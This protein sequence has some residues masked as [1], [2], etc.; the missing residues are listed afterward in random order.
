MKKCGAILLILVVM[1]L[2]SACSEQKNEMKTT[3][4]TVSGGQAQS[5]TNLKDVTVGK[6]GQLIT[7]TFD[8]VNG[9]N[10]SG[11]KE[12]AMQGV[13]TYDLSFCENPM[14]ML[15]R[16]EGVRHWAYQVN[17]ILQD[18][19]G[20]IEGMLRV[21]PVG[22][23]TTTDFYINLSKKVKFCVAESD[24]KLTVCL[25]P[26]QTQ[27]QQAYY[28][29]GEFFNE[30]QEGVLPEE[31][32]LT[33]TLADDKISVLMISN[34][35]FSQEEAQ[36]F[37]AELEQKYAASL[38]EKTLRI[39]QN[40]TLSLPQYEDQQIIDDLKNKIL[41]RR[42][43][44]E[45]KANLFFADGRFI[46]WMNNGSQALFA[47]SETAL[48]ES[49]SVG[50]QLYLADKKGNKTLLFDYELSTVTEGLFSPDDS[51][52]VILEQTDENQVCSIY[53]FASKKLNMLDE[54]IIGN[55][56]AGCAWSSDG[57]KLYLLSGEDMFSVF[58]CDVQTMQ[59]T[60]LRQELSIDGNL[61]CF[62]DAL[63]YMDVVQDSVAIVRHSIVSGDFTTVPSGEF[64]SM[65]KSGTDI[66]T[67]VYSGEQEEGYGAL[68][69]IRNFGAQEKTIVSGQYI[70]Q[71]FFSNDGKRIYYSVESED[72]NFVYTVYEYNIETEESRL[73]F[74]MIEGRLMPAADDN[75]LILNIT[76]EKDNSMYSAT[77][78]IEIK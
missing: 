12:S 17:S 11:A 30:Y 32:G 27:E 1:G 69:L 55:N 43:E 57:K 23:R 44:K 3:E 20:L 16:I 61:Y 5:D 22:N 13:P 47:K 7:I 4:Q 72:E 49:E 34:A 52:L 78:F 51:K 15:L 63:Y 2:F 75:A 64:F 29:A 33:P 39:I 48:H 40:G 76:Y 68:K 26:I 8:F 25:E 41:I 65:N 74:D 21:L 59:I 70:A 46:C 45:E 53:D 6:D 19:T 73:L 10:Q 50:D 9:D 38:G 18:E 36:L 14:R 28:V 67:Q 71:Y 42:Q 58:C 31:A 35:F 24:G 56:V 77:Y 60:V 54:M 37:K 66:L 62:E